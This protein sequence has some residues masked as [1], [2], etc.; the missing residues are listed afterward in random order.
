MDYDDTDHVGLL[1][2]FCTHK[3][4]TC[5]LLTFLAAF[6]RIFH[7]AR[8][9]VATFQICTSAVVITW[10]AHTTVDNL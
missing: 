1:S 6:S 4:V 5:R 10:R 3:K 7:R 9:V 2:L 8:A